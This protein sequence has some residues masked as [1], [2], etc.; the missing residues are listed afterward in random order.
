MGA[1]LFFRVAP[2]NASTARQ[3]NEIITTHPSSEAIQN[4]TEKRQSQSPHFNE[5]PVLDEADPATGWD[6]GEGFLNSPS[7]GEKQAGI[8]EH[9]TQLFEALHA[10]AAFE[11]EILASSCLLRV[12]SFSLDQYQRLTDTGD[13][14]CGPTAPRYKLMLHQCRDINGFPTRFTDDLG[15]KTGLETDAAIELLDALV[16]LHTESMTPTQFAAVTG[17]C[18]DA[19][20]TGAEILEQQGLI[21]ASK[22]GFISVKEPSPDTPLPRLVVDRAQKQGL[23]KQYLPSG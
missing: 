17:Q 16:T 3:A 8:F 15:T 20:E 14:L 23:L 19:A 2:T 1:D 21:S 18:P 6:V 10:T 4:L 7:Y 9:W 13:A 11:T 22:Y 12:L 5:E